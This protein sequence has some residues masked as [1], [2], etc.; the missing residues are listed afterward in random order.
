MHEVALTRLELGGELQQAVEEEQFELHFQPIVSLETAAILGAEALIR[1][2]HPERGLLAP[3]EF[4][5]LAEETG[6]I[7]PLG[8][9]VL[10]EAVRALR[11]WQDEHPELPLYIT[12]NISMRQL[13][14]VGIVD[15]VRGALREADVPADRLVIEITESFLADESEAP[16][17][18]LQRLRAL[19]VRLAVD[20]FGTGYSALSYLQRFPI[21]ILKIDRS[22]VEHARRSSSSVNLVRS[23]VQLGQSLHLGLVAEGIEEAE[24]AELLREMG[25]PAGQG[26]YFAKPLAPE[27]FG[28]LLAS[29]QARDR[30]RT[31]LLGL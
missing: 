12:A 18:R 26:Y 8:R 10:T 9:W 31:E 21:D 4:L 25:V 2:R 14:D 28:A 6:L 23:I 24:Q 17:V 29:G 27:R 22:F 16:R 7:V 5:G 30:A 1:W 13:Y 19:G 20:D 15:H 3:R 11:T